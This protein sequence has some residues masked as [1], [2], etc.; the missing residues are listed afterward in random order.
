MIELQCGA[1]K[2]GEADMLCV[3]DKGMEGIIDLFANVSSI[4][5]MPHTTPP[6][7]HTHVHTHSLHLALLFEFTSQMRITRR[8]QLYTVTKQPDF[9]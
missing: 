6:H 5:S 7:P 9:D 4:E 8:I 3:G 2:S 1:D